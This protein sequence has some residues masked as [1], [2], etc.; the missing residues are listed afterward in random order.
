MPTCDGG[1]DGALTVTASGGTPGY[2][3]RF[4]GGAF[5]ANN[6]FANLSNGIYNVAIR[7][8]NNCE[9]AQD[10]V[11]NELIL[12]L[13]PDAVTLVEPRCTGEANARYQHSFEQWFRAFWL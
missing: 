6:V 2:T 11:V 3:Y 13:D 7:D 8:V 9:F 12:E 5:S 10:I 1:T 4:E